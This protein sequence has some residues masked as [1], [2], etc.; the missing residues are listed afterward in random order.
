MNITVH[1]LNFKVHENTEEYALRKLER[2]E[3]YMPRI[4]DIRLELSLH[5]SKRGEDFTIAQLTVVHERGAILRA[6]ETQPGRNQTA[7]EA[8]ITETVDK[9]Y[10]R[11]SRFQG[12][13][14]DHRRHRNR[15]SA[16]LEELELAEDIP[17]EMV[18]ES[19]ADPYA[20]FNGAEPEVV[21]HKQVQLEPM[22]EEEA[23]DQMELLGHAFF[24]FL[25]GQTG[26]V[27]VLYRRS[28]GNYGVL[29]PEAAE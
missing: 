6:E 26:N 3:R 18:E 19:V 16:T 29:V 1:G 24:M 28:E 14:R 17:D 21:R 12:K 7:L 4:R 23:I 9:M 15:F 27:N 2:L 20:D 25:N 22:T 8:V 11:I 13:R 5:N 10:R